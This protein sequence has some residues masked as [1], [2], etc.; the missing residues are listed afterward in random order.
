MPSSKSNASGHD[1]ATLASRW[2]LDN[3]SLCYDRWRGRAA[4]ESLLSLKDALSRTPQETSEP[5]FSVWAFGLEFIERLRRHRPEFVNEIE[6]VLSF[7]RERY[8]P[9]EAELTTGY[10]HGD[11]HPMNVVWGESDILKLIDWEFC[12]PKPELYDV[13]LMAGCFA[14]ENPEG[15]TG[16]LSRN[17]SRHFGGNASALNIA[18]R[19][20]WS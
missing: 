20:S 17:S 7:V 8:A 16:E 1:H 19:S 9:C 12:G 4:A 3:V 14:M 6:D 10:C 15:L 2:G 11:F 18:G 5:V 13:A